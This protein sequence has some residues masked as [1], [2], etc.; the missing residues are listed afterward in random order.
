M[1]T[2]PTTL[3][4]TDSETTSLVN[5]WRPNGR[6]VWEATFTRVEAGRVTGT[7]TYLVGDVDLQHAN[8]ESLEIGG[9]RDRHPH[10]RGPGFVPANQV[11]TEA[12]LA[13]L[14]WEATRIGP[15]RDGRVHLVAANPTFEHENFSNLLYRHGYGDGQWSHHLVDINALAAGATG[16][17]PPWSS[18]ALSAAVGV[19]RAVYGRAH[20]SAA[21]TDW[22]QAVY[23]AVMADRPETYDIDLGGRQ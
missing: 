14:V 3:L 12:Q 21:D 8:P 15:D 22:H 23:T 9:F 11:V 10:G 20:T 6:R 17:P 2:T 1:T 7:A 4:F 18:S 5:P 16:T 19:D 13:A